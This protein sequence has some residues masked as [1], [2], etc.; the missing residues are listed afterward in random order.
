MFTGLVEEI[1]TIKAIK[2]LGGGKRI[3]VE[4]NKIM[5]DLK[6]DDSVA[7]NGACQTVVARTDK[8]FD[9]E[10]VEE[11]LR[12]TTLSKFGAGKKI[13]LERA[14]K[15]GGRM[16]GHLVQGHVD[17]TGRIVSI[18]PETAGRLVWIE[19]PEKFSRYVV[20][21]GSICIDGISLT[22]ARTEGS[23]LMVAVI[24]HTWNVTVLREHHV[25]TEINLEFDIIGKYVEKMTQ[26][27]SREAGRGESFLDQYMDQPDW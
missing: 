14:M 1:G 10:A 27:F 8:T 23:K 26:A 18:Q 6:I 7:L 3:T 25:G 5:D 11:T 16:G 21:V 24:P 2:P 9:V 22:V 13:N 19:F 4:A 15:L 20:P 17:C 12:K